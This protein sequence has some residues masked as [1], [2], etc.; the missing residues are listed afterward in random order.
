ML[1]TFLSQDRWEGLGG[2]TEPRL[3]RL[4]RWLQWVEAVRL[5]RLLHWGCVTII[6]PINVGFMIK[7]KLLSSPVVLS[8]DYVARKLAVI[9]SG[10]CDQAQAMETLMVCWS[11]QKGP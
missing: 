4:E 8:H 1:G 5:L 9:A 10:V 11:F 6:L 2:T 7:H 3:A